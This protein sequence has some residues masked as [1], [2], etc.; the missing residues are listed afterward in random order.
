M[1]EGV[2]RLA[3]VVGVL[4]ALAGVPR[5]QHLFYILE[6]HRCGFAYYQRE[7][8]A[9]PNATIDQVGPNRIV[10][11]ET[12]PPVPSFSAAKPP[13]GFS[14]TTPY[15][16]P[17]VYKESL[18]TEPPPRWYE[19]LVVVVPPA[20]GFCLAWAAVRCVAWVVEGFLRPS[21]QL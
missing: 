19:Y 5:S 16:W 11:I 1:S 8:A 6:L 20:I 13:P 2:R 7:L 10:L 4:G 12:G 18:S 3:L 9:H 15:W 17:Q 21:T 14:A